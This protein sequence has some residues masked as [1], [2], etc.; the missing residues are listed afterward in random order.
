M[1]G[2][3]LAVACGWCAVF[4][5]GAMA[6]TEAQEIERGRELGI[7]AY[8]YGQ[9]LLDMERIFNTSTSVNVATEHGYAPVNQL[10]HFKHL[11][12]TNESVVVAPNDDTLY[13]TGWLEL[14]KKQPMVVHVPAASRFDVIEMVSPWTEN[15]A[16]VG[17]EASGLLPPGDYLVAGPGTDEGMEEADGLKVIHSPYDRVWLIGRVV[18]EGPSDTEAL[19]LEEQMKIVP[20][21][22]WLKEGLNYE[23]KSTSARKRPNRPIA[24][25]PGTGEH[26]SPLLYW[27]ALGKA[28]KQ[29]TPPEADK[30]ILEELATVN[31]GPGKKPS[32]GKRRQGRDQGAG[33]SRRRG[34][35]TGASSTSK[36][37][38]LN[39]FAKHNGWL[40]TG[41]GKYGTNYVLA[42]RGRQARRRRTRA[43]R[44]DLPARAHRRH[45]GETQRCRPNATWCTSPPATS[46]S[47]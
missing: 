21:K 47:R 27:K 5:S 23:P 6:E 40:V 33:R 19:P 16:N 29:F 24:H 44:L 8:I 41:A 15:F 45:D 10:S 3:L 43:Q 4:A 9:P 32:K 31:I 2:V 14:K 37:R 28:L 25:I 22:N 36:K 20:L 46:R 12:T 1:L 30:P 34:S 17:T 39:G 11:V 26:E 13:A 18:V 35:R 7:K 42:C 38:F